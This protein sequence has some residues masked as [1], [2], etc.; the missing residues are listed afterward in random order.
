[1]N[2]MMAKLKSKSKKKQSNTNS[3]TPSKENLDECDDTEED[4]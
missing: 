4:S 3:L 2:S 1:M